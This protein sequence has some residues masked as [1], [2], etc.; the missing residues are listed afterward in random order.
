ME[1]RS[2][3]FNESNIIIGDDI[4]KEKIMKFEFTD[5]GT[6]GFLNFQKLNRSHDFSRKQQNS[7]IEK[8]S[9]PSPIEKSP[10]DNVDSSYETTQKHKH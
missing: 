4:P 2:H 8:T 9:M 3:L 5:G 7:E 6:G 1:Q 10:L